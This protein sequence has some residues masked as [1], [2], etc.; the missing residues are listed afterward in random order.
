MAV[1]VLAP[2]AAE[3]GPGSAGPRRGWEVRMARGVSHVRSR[4]Q[5]GGEP[6]VVVHRQDGVLDSLRGGVEPGAESS[7]RDGGVGMTEGGMAEVL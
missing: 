1:G 2:G 3:Q 7:G 5:V 4:A 6:A